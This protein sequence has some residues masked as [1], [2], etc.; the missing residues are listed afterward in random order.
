[1]KVAKSDIGAVY[2]TREP[3]NERVLIFEEDDFSFVWTKKEIRN[4][5]ALWN[6]GKHIADIAEEI[7]R[8]QDEITVLIIW[9]ARHG[10]LRKREGGVLG[11]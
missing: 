1:V 7:K 11:S 3:R 6:D 5:Q 2:M 8:D 9:L 4:V 10:R